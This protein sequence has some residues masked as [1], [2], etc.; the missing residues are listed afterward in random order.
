VALALL[1]PAIAAAEPSP[2]VELGR[3][4]TYDLTRTSFDV[5]GWGSASR[6]PKKTERVVVTCTVT[7]IASFWAS[8]RPSTGVASRIECDHEL[9]P[10]IAGDYAV[11][12]DGLFR[13]SDFAHPV[14]GDVLLA[15]NPKPVRTVAHDP[16]LHADRVRGLRPRGAIWCVFDDTSG[17][18]LDAGAT[19][20]QCFGATGIASGDYDGGGGD[21][22]RATYRLRAT[23]AAPAARTP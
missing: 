12:P 1:W 2:F 19:T 14:L 7:Q 9:D 11:T 4:W 16:A 23:K 17:V 8:P 3:T 20:E 15:A 18:D 5:E 21:W 10:P 13:I 6:P 22:R